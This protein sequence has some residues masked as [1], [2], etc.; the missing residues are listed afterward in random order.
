MLKDLWR[1]LKDNSM[2]DFEG[3]NYINGEWRAT[4]DMYT[5]LNPA[6]GKAQGAFPLSNKS[7][8]EKALLSARKAFRTWRKVS[9]FT[10]SDYLNKVAQIIERDKEKLAKIISL[11]TGKNYNE[12]IAEVNEAL[13][14]AQFAFG[15]GRYSHGEAVSSEIADK[16][17]YML[18]KPKGV[19]AIVTP[20]NFPL[21]IGMFWNA[22]PALV[23]G[24]TIVIK[25]S[26]D[27]PM[28]TQAA[29][30]IYAEAGIPRGVINL[31]HGDGST[32]DFVVRGDCDHI[33]F[34][35]SADV[36]Q[37]IRKVAA[38]SWHKTTSCELG[39]KSACIV[40]D[41]VEMDL[42]VDSAI[43]SAFKLSGQRC[44]SSGRMIVQRTVYEEFCQRFVE[45]ASKLKTGNPFKS[46]LG[47]S[48]CPDGMVWEELTPNNDVYYGPI[49][50][51]QGFNKIKKFNSLVAS[52]PKAEI[53]LS[54]KYESINDKAFYSTPM[55]YKSEWRDCDL[56]GYLRNEVFGPHVA[57]IPFDTIDDAIRIYNDTEYGL[58]VGV[59]TNDFRKARIM[60]DEW[61][62]GMIYWNGGSIAAESHL[63]FGGVKKSGNGFPSAARTFRA[64][65]HEISWT[66]NHA[67]TL[68]FPQG[69]K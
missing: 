24:N 10:R 3:R 42:A 2:R 35:G 53:L 49:I 4:A 39:S 25:P 43:A 54:P 21:A 41:D 57:I 62:A 44:V 50:N 16:D 37:H 38:E 48:G 9:R 12:S 47:T 18:R 26:E 20:F 69:M 31:V 64:V 34:T 67:E 40:F 65:T 68:A 17:A 36:G 55:V 59:L 5:K 51:E 58:A 19:I 30:Q 46:N 7:E 52:D 45:K 23:E 14:M 15:S 11:E 13:H 56:G 61:E 6:T 8:V 32:G 60:R 22:A 66:V 1:A 27:A 63:A 33:C 29:V 28:S